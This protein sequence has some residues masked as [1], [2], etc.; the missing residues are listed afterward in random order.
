M[1]GICWRSIRKPP[2]IRQQRIVVSCSSIPIRANWSSNNASW[3]IE[4]P[5]RNWNNSRAVLS[6]ERFFPKQAVNHGSSLYT[7]IWST[8]P[9]SV[10]T[11]PVRCQINSDRQC[12]GRSLIYGASIRNH[13]DFHCTTAFGGQGR[14]N[15]EMTD[16]SGLF[17]DSGGNIVSAD[18]KNDRIQVSI[19]ARWVNTKRSWSFRLDILLDGWIQGIDETQWTHQ[20]SIGYLRQSRG[21]STVCFVLSGWMCSS[22]QYQLLTNW[23]F[24][25]HSWSIVIYIH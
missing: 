17:V 8:L 15:G 18:S 25:L 21:N 4:S 5:K 19:L 24:A 23:V 6:K 1:I 7:T 10:R 2:I 9:I 3:S 20:A 16:P 11:R 14:G 22:I 13:F 12:I